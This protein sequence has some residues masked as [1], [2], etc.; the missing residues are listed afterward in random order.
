MLMLMLMSRQFTRIL[1]YAYACAYAC[2]VRVNQ[3]CV[4]LTKLPNSSHTVVNTLVA[5]L[6]SLVAHYP[7]MPETDQCLSCNCSV[8]HHWCVNSSVCLSLGWWTSSVSDTPTSFEATVQTN[9]DTKYG[10]QLQ[11]STLHQHLP[12][13]RPLTDHLPTITGH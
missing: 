2:V 12:V 9:T 1:S 10:W 6:Q 13:Y 8:L 7:D 5:L 4:C 3:A 11:H